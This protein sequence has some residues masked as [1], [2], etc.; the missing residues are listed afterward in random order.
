MSTG[1]RVMVDVPQDIFFLIEK[2]RRN[3]KRSPFIAN[4][5]C[6]Y[7][8]GREEETGLFKQTQ[9]HA[10]ESQGARGVPHFGVKSPRTPVPVSVPRE[11]H[12]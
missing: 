10:A 3:I 4:I 5:L 2:D 1:T 8:E 7:Y 12:G 11:S 6:R 9:L